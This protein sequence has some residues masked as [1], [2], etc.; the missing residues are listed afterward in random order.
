MDSAKLNDW[1]QVFGIFALVASLIFVGLQMQQD[2][3]I[4]KVMI[5]QSR[6][7]NTA[8]IYASL[9]SSPDA[10]ALGIKSLTGD[11]PTAQDTVL[12]GF[13]ASA[14]FTLTDN[15]HYQYEEGFLP[16]AHWLSVR[17]RMKSGFSN[18]PIY[19]NHAEVNLKLYRPTFRKELVEI[20]KEIDGEETT[21]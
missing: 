6:A 10:A 2:R 20:M 16:E 14:L 15:S 17:E 13:A 7:S 1:M 8:E 12:G 11:L 3:E 19:R 21:N 9:A 18:L 5:Y 4:A